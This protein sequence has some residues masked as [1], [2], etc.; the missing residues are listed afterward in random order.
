VVSRAAGEDPAG[1]GGPFDALLALQIAPPWRRDVTES[2]PLPG[3]VRDAVAGLRTAGCVD[4]VVGLVPDPEY[5]RDGRLRVLLWRRPGDGPFARYEKHEYLVPMAELAA[6]VRALA[7]PGELRRF[8]GYRE[9]T[10]ARD[11]LVC[12]HGSRDVSCGRFGYAVYSSLRSGH[13]APRSLRVWRTSHLGGH[14]FAPTLLELPEGRYWGHLDLGAAGDL[15]TRRGPPSGLAR[16]YRGWA[17]FGTQFEQI[18]ER[19]ILARE[20]WGWSEYLKQGRSTLPDEGGERA[21]VR[22]SYRSPDGT[23]SG[24]YEALVEKSGSVMTLASSGTDPLEEA[25]QYRVTRMDKVPLEHHDL[26]CGC[27]PAS[28]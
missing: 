14:R 7:D 20:G 10:P 13:A 24:A 21:E 4:K 8:E 12:T 16:F 2:T 26:A 5:S 18:A 23:V 15:V 11:V 1:T 19:E 9:E 27:P 17:G 22:V 3:E 6:L 25:A 28:V